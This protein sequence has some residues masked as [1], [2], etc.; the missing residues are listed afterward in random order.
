M[1]M[2]HMDG[3]GQNAKGGASCAGACE[4]GGVGEGSQAWKVE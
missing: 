1:E 4:E 3:T 2:A